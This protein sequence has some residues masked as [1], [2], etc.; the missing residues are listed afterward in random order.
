MC[1]TVGL[2]TGCAAAAFCP[3]AA[4]RRDGAATPGYRSPFAA[5]DRSASVR[6]S[7]RRVLASTELDLFPEDLVP[8]AGHPVVGRLRPEL[9]R[10]LLTQQLHRYLGF[11]AKLEYLVVNHVVLGIAH[12]SIEVPVPDEMRF[13]ALRIYTDEAY[14]ALFSVDLGRQVT[15]RTGIA[16][17]GGRPFF[18]V[19][20]DALKARHDPSLAGLVDLLFTI[21]S[22]TLISATLTDVARST[23]VE[24]SVAALVRDHAV[25]E[26]RHHAYFAQYLR[27]LWAALDAGERRFAACLF[28]E[29][30]DVFLRPDTADVGD[31]LLGYGLSRDEVNEVLADTFDEQVRAS[32][33]R[34][35]AARLLG[36][37]D[38]VGVFD[39]PRALDLA[40]EHDL[41]PRA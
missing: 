24:P 4:L 30:I 2:F 31:E 6:S 7:P 34:A 14:H 12:G 18:L 41:V 20:L 29:L 40:R 17:R 38:D 37:L 22:E 23:S 15:A 9:R 16:P 25:D 36:Y 1:G 27:H 39:D 19:R 32:Y 8:V 21:V 11:T 28:P 13:D 33:N 35:T 5:W 3:V 10:R 26:G